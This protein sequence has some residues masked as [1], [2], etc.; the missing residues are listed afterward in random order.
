[1]TPTAS[2]IAAARVLLLGFGLTTVL[3]ASAF[4]QSASRQRLITGCGGSTYASARRAK[5]LADARKAGSRAT[6]APVARANAQTEAERPTV[7]AAN[8][9]VTKTTIN[10]EA[11]QQSNSQNSYDAI[12]DVPGVQ[13]TDTRGGAITDSLQI[14]GI[15]LSS[16][17]SYRLDGGLPIANNIAMPIE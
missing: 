9:V 4:A 7:D 14:R 10:S 11:L 6:P 12:K 2:R 8:G 17:T 3:S 15:K 13:Q 16:T 5:E 1:M